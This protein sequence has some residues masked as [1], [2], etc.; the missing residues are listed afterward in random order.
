MPTALASSLI[1]VP[2]SLGSPKIVGV[3]SSLRTL[4]QLKGRLTVSN[5]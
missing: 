2:V 5:Q 4:K 3:Y 1:L